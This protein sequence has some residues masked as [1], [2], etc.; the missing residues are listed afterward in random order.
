MRHGTASWTSSSLNNILRA[1][2]RRACAA[3]SRSKSASTVNFWPGPRRC[4]AACR[5]RAV[6]LVP[7]RALPLAAA[8]APVPPLFN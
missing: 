5:V 2:P 6:A 1:E 8:G 3:I 4:A 7:V